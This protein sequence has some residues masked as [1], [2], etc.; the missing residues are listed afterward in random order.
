MIVVQ[1]KTRKV[2]GTC[3]L[4][5]INAAHGFRV[6]LRLRNGRNSDLRF[7]IAR[8]DTLR[9]RAGPVI[10]TEYRVIAYGFADARFLP[11]F[12]RTP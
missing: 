11:G 5:V 4:S 10:S 3:A 2:L 6:C 1:Q 8:F 12:K 9:S 7:R